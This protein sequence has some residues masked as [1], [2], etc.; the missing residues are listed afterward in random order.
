VQRA[1]IIA[2]LVF[3]DIDLRRYY[4]LARTILTNPTSLPLARLPPPTGMAAAGR[5]S[6][7]C[8]CQDGSHD[9]TEAAGRD[10]GR[11]QAFEGSS[12]GVLGDAKLLYLLR[13]A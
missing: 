3:S 13:S 12:S 9:V 8:E 10:V 2:G 1:D 11:R 5:C 4:L 6:R 7:G